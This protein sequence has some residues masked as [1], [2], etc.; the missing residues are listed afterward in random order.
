MAATGCTCC[1]DGLAL[2][3]PHSNPLARLPGQ[4]PVTWEIDVENT[5][6]DLIARAAK[7]L[8]SHGI[9]GYVLLH[10]AFTLLLINLFSTI[11]AV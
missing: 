2:A 4:N 11:S 1:C 6:L 9:Q 7:F 8:Y 10:V 3:M 5:W